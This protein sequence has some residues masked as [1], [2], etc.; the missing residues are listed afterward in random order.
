VDVC[1]FLWDLLFHVAPLAWLA[2][3]GT[4]QPEQPLPPNWPLVSALLQRSPLTPGVPLPDDARA[5]W[6]VGQHNA[7]AYRA[8]LLGRC[9]GLSAVWPPHPDTVIAVW[10][11]VQAREPPDAIRAS[12][13]GCPLPS[14]KWR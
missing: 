11:S 14:V 3:D 4:V 10:T 2:V 6:F 12:Q 7:I 13:V 1:E 5:S 8:E 9:I